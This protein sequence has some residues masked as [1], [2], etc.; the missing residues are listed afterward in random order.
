[1]EENA[2]NPP[3]AVDA[4]KAPKGDGADVVLKGDVKGAA[5]FEVNGDEAGAGDMAKGDGLA[6]IVVGDGGLGSG[7]GFGSPVTFDCEGSDPLSPP[8]PVSDEDTELELKRGAGGAAFVGIVVEECGVD[9]EN[10]SRGLFVLYFCAN[11]VNISFS[12]P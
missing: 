11:F 5:L 9:V 12:R 10:S 4:L 3:V 7:T 1:M 2:P 8:S 6:V